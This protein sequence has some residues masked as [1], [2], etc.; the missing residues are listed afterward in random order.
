MQLLRSALIITSFA[1]LSPTTLITHAQTT[2][3][4]ATYPSKPLRYIVAFPAGGTTDLLGRLIGQKLT[5][6][7]G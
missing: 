7:W 5:E 2:T 4:A 6:T 1:T 3:P